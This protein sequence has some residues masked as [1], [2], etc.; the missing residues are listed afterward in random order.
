VQFHWWDYEVPRYV[1][2]AG[3]LAELQR[4]GKIRLIG[5]TNFDVAR[6]N[7]IIDAGVPVVANQLQYSLF[8]RRAEGG[9]VSFCQ[10][11]DLDLL[12][13]GSLA[14]GFLSS[15][16]VG[17][18]EPGAQLANRSLTKYKL[19]IDEFGGWALYQEILGVLSKIAHRHQ[20]S[21]ANIAT[22]WVLDRP[23]V[24]A[25]LVGARSTTHLQDNLRVFGLELGE[26]DYQLLDGVLSRA[27]GPI[28]QPFELERVPGGRHSTIMKTDLNRGSSGLVGSEV[29]PRGAE[30]G[31]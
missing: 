17:Q 5:T 20:V 9:M 4:A 13:Y 7:E 15:F 8:D 21:P 16:W 3:W 25:V 23:G 31:S 28:G 11:H 1:E 14:G 29:D 26:E 22:R 19:I 2:V 30:R 10:K 12:C 18:P 27:S 24:A 6:L